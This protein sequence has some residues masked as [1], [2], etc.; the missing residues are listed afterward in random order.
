MNKFS[1]LEQVDESSRSLGGWDEML[2]RVSTGR[3]MK[4]STEGKV[5]KRD[6]LCI[7]L[8]DASPKPENTSHAIK[9]HF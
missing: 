9:S 3:L 1:V 4:Q 5:E 2:D 8:N 6:D 7:I